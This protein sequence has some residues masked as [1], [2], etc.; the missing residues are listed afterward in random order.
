MSLNMPISGG[1]YSPLML[2]I[3]IERKFLS[4]ERNIAICSHVLLSQNK[5]RVIALPHKHDTNISL[6]SHLMQ[7]QG[8]SSH[9]QRAEHATLQA[10]ITSNGFIKFSSENEIE[11]SSSLL[12]P[13]P[14]RDERRLARLETA[15]FPL[16]GPDPPDPRQSPGPRRPG[17]AIPRGHTNPTKTH[18]KTT[19]TITVWFYTPLMRCCSSSSQWPVSVV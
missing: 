3:T 6:P 11:P 2:T 10:E 9:Q 1:L 18:R 19:T 15:C 5:Y 13:P 17:A 7:K 16:F 8:S 4:S 14:R 12:L